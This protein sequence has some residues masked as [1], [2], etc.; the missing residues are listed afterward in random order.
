MVELRGGGEG[1]RGGQRCN[2]DC[3]LT[4]ALES[5]LETKTCTQPRVGGKYNCASDDK[6]GMKAG[7]MTFNFPS[8][9]PGAS[10]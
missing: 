1:G 9:P 5:Q 8:P 2:N 4:C 3:C 6:K 10:G 7:H